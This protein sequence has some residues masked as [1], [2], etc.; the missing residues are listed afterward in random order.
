MKTD[1]Y[2]KAVLSVIAACLVY[3]ALGTPPVAPVASAQPPQ[4]VVIEGVYLPDGSVR[5]IHMD[6]SGRI[7]V[8]AQ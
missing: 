8:L 3:F 1:L 2:T 4:R 7:L 5:R 6:T